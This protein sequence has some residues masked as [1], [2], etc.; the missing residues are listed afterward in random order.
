MTPSPTSNQKSENIIYFT[1]TFHADETGFHIDSVVTEPLESAFEANEES[2]T[3]AVDINVA[4]VRTRYA[5]MAKT[6]EE[7]ED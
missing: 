5:I 2:G 1:G 6:I 3:A 7:E 4:G